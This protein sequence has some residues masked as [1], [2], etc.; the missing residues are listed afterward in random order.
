MAT[1][2]QKFTKANKSSPVI[3]GVTLR[4]MAGGVVYTLDDG[5]MHELSAMDS[6]TLPKGFPI[7]KD[8]KENLR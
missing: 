8:G 7:W 4:G 2:V 1:P 3:S 6:I 5:S